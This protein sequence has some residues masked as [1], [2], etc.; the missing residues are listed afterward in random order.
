MKQGMDVIMMYMKANQYV[1]TD[2]WAS[3]YFE[4]AVDASQNMLVLQATR[5]INNL[6]NVVLAKKMVTLNSYNVYL[7]QLTSYPLSIAVA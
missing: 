3:G 6:V 1:V 4:P 7:Q 5:D 2:R